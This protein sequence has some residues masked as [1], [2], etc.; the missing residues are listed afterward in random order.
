MLKPYRVLDLT[1]ERGLLAGKIFA[2]LGA[3]VIQVEPPGGSPA[4]RLPPLLDARDPASSAW[5]AAYACNKRGITL[6]LDD[7][8]DR[9]RLRQ[10]AATADFLFESEEPGVMA[11]RGLGYE[12]LAR[13]NPRLIHASITAFG[14]DGPR[15]TDPA[16]DLTLWAAGGAL[17]PAGGGLLT[18]RAGDRPSVRISVPQAYLHAA[19]DA[20]AGA[21]VAHFERLKSG[22]GQHVDIAA[23]Q[24]VTQVS[25]AGVLS[26]LVG[27]TEHRPRS[28][29]DAGPGITKW[30]CKDGYLDFAPARH[31]N[32]LMLW[33]REEGACEDADLAFDWT[34]LREVLAGGDEAAVAEV[35]R[36]TELIRAFFASK[37]KL[38]LLEGAAT[39][40]CMLAPILDVADVAANP[41]LADRD[42]WRAIDGD[43]YPRLR[44]PGPFCRVSGQPLPYRRPAPR[45]GEHNAEVFAELTS[46][47]SLKGTGDPAR[48]ARTASTHEGRRR[49]PVAVAVDTQR[50]QG[51]TAAPAQGELPLAG[52]RVL[53]LT[54]VVAGPMIGRALADFGAIV[55][56]VDS[57][58]RVDGSRPVFPFHGGVPGPERSALYGDVNAGKLGIT[59]NLATAEAR[60][61][62]LDLVRWADVLTEA[63]TPGV[64]ARWGLGYERLRELNPGLIMLCTSINGETGR[65]AGLWGR[66]TPV[67]P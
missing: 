36:L 40:R 19:A 1:D 15:A 21:L 16:T 37:T 58:R 67:R 9:G 33:M 7:A 43:P 3:D 46:F 56:K 52:L 41:H 55:I 14:Q 49:A 29:D 13:L 62:L 31:T 59:L 65:Y 30:R 6:D 42:F 25:M 61:V 48:R 12:D 50:I 39:R 63:F 10:L 64:M 32:N 26:H 8:A 27:H 38:E 4:R 18:A 24:S 5:W 17:L 11:A 53:D 2:D 20:A 44:Y 23:Q 34:R 57:R 45:L 35:A 66:A 60:V 47:P 51:S 54:W 22:L 28:T